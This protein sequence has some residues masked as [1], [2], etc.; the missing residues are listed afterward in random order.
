[1]GSPRLSLPHGS[2]T[3]RS[4][5][6]TDKSPL[7]RL[8]TMA[9]TEDEMRDALRGFAILVPMQMHRALDGIMEARGKQP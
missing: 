5:Y 3:Q 2:I 1:M 7:Q 6:V 4:S 8:A 9:L